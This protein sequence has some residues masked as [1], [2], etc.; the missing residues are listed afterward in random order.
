[1]PT[2][3][4]DQSRKY[5]KGVVIWSSGPTDNSIERYKANIR[6]KIQSAGRCLTRPISIL[7]HSKRQTRWRVLLLTRHTHHS[8]PVI[9]VEAVLADAPESCL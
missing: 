8:S 5:A 9:V 7:G 2:K 4:I 3:K 1:M 6:I